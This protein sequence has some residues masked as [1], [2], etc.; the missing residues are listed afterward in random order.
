EASARRRLYRHPKVEHQ[1]IFGEWDAENAE[2]LASGECPRGEPAEITE[3]VAPCG[4]ALK[5]GSDFAELQSTLRAQPHGGEGLLGIPAFDGQR[6]RASG[7]GSGFAIE[8]NV[9][10]AGL[11]LDARRT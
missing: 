9:G 3:S 11:R 2:A 7:L 8:V 6:G 10:D 4:R 1:P 5:L